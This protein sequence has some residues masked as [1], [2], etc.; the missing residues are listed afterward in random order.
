MGKRTA[1][2]NPADPSAF[3]QFCLRRKVVPRA[4]ALLG[5]QSQNTVG[6]PRIQRATIQRFKYFS[7]GVPLAGIELVVVNDPIPMYL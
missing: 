3:A 6:H 2:D 5:D 1:H 7:H 4:Q